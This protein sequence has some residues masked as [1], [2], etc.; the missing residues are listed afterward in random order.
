MDDRI[1]TSHAGS[2]PRPDELVELNRALREGELAD[3][4][5]FHRRLAQ[6]VSDVVARQR[7]LG[8]DIVNDG[9]YGHTMGQRYDYGACWNYVFRPSVAPVC[10][11]PI[12]YTGRELRDRP[13]PQRYQVFVDEPLHL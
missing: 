11:G 4:A 9:E 12:T 5:G 6:G 13:K 10:R 7:E 2:L 3:E 1:L 8:I